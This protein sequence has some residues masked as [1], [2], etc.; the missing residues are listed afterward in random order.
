[1]AQVAFRLAVGIQSGNSAVSTHDIK[2]SGERSESAARADRA[3]V[4]VRSTTSDESEALRCANPV[5]RL[6]RTLGPAS[7]SLEERRVG[8]GTRHQLARGM[9]HGRGK[10]RWSHRPDPVRRVSVPKARAVAGRQ[11][12]AGDEALTRLRP[13]GLH[14]LRLVQWD[15]VVD[16]QKRRDGRRRLGKRAVSSGR[17][18]RGAGV[19]QVGCTGERRRDQDGESKGDGSH[20]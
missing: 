12:P 8:R 6:T 15:V 10:V 17:F 7:P 18:C 4:L 16:I 11:V 19:G 5:D 1:M 3:G 2:L 20:R 13:R 9:W 14:G